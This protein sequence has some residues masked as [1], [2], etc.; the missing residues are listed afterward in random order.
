MILISDCERKEIVQSMLSYNAIYAY[1]YTEMITN[2]FKENLS[3][4]FVDSLSTVLGLIRFSKRFEKVFGHSPCDL[5][6]GVN[7]SAI[8]SSGTVEKPIK[9]ILKSVNSQIYI[10]ANYEFEFL[11]TVNTLWLSMVSLEAQKIRN[12]ILKE[13]GE[14][15]SIG[16]CFTVAKELSN[17]CETMG[18]PACVAYA[19]SYHA[20]LIVDGICID[21]SWMDG[22]HFKE[23]E[24]MEATK[25]RNLDCIDMEDFKTTSI[26]N[27]M[28]VYEEYMEEIEKIK[29]RDVGLL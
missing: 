23:E 3:S 22:C 21:G 15:P 2:R 26:K 16:S 7:G 5:I 8:G 27:Y 17:Y 4:N 29:Y 25:L 9:E 6:V 12:R 11:E 18:I 13:T 14:E 20:T 19:K 10:N 24:I 1:D 28:K